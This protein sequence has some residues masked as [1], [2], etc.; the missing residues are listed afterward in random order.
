MVAFP[1]IPFP[2]WGMSV[3]HASGLETTL[4]RAVDLVPNIGDAI[5]IAVSLGF[6]RILTSGG[7]VSAAEGASVIRQ[8]LVQAK[9]RISIMAGAGITADN[10][11]DLLRICDLREIHAS[12]SI[13]VNDVNCKLIQYGFVS[14]VNKQTSPENVAALK[15]VLDN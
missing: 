15:M 12:C 9:D 14:E 2:I 10:A 6:T 1:D 5:E 4:H 3:Q 8:M 7:K 13:A 11:A